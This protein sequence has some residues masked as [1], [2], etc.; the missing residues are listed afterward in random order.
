MP[1]TQKFLPLEEVDAIVTDLRRR[2]EFA[3]VESAAVEE[4]E[5]WNGEEVLRV[6]LIGVD[7]AHADW[8][9]AQPRQK[10]IRRAIGERGDT[11]WVYFTWSTL[12]EEREAAEQGEEDLF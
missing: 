1:V 4:Y 5:D 2:P 12:E 3:G 11:R 10:V 6:T 8:A 9:F 7:D